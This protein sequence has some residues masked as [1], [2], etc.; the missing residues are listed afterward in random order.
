[1]IRRQACV[2]RARK[3][4]R[5]PRPVV[6]TYTGMRH[7]AIVALLCGIGWAD[8]PRRVVTETSIEI[9]DPIRFVG[10]SPEI[11][12]SSTRML[13]AIAATL[14]GNPSIRVMAVRAFGV[15]ATRDQLVLGE[16]RARA[17]VFE[18]VRRGVAQ[19]RLRAQG[20]VRPDRGTDPGPELIILERAPSSCGS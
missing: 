6:T 10:T 16:R 4:F 17:V 2:T 15:D 11:A 5:A 14:N 13:D 20:A 7:L 3:V 19:A 8:S 12:P 18:L 1:M 9:Y